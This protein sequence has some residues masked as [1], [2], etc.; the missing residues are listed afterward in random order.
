MQMTK[1]QPDM[2]PGWAGLEVATIEDKILAHVR[3]GSTVYTDDFLSY[4]RLKKH[5]KHGVV[6]HG[7]GEYV[8]GDIHSN[9]AESFWALFKRG[10]HGT[11]HKMSHKHLQRYVDE[12]AFRYNS[13][14]IGMD[15]RFVQ[16]VDRLA[17]RGKLSYKTLT[18]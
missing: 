4:L 14:G 16:A 1:D 9:S 6:A 11:Y 18:A 10:Y 8:K 5:F 2:V 7:R 15:E 13:R 12:F 17:S 3:K